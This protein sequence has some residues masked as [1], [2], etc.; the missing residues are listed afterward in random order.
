MKIF[1]GIKQKT[2][3][4]NLE[5]INISEEWYQNVLFGGNVCIR[6]YNQKPL[7]CRYVIVHLYSNIPILAII[8][9]RVLIINSF[10]NGIN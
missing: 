1:T 10:Y 4:W 3:F 5:Q 8:N 2:R 6:C 9:R 7:S